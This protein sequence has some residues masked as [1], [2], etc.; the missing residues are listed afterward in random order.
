M[1]KFNDLPLKQQLGVVLVVALLITGG[2]YYSLFKPMTEANRTSREALE[3]KQAENAQLEP[4]LSKSQEMESTIAVLRGQLETLNQI[5]P[6]EKE[7]PQFMKLLQAAAASSG[8]EVRRYTAHPPASREF[9]TEVP[10]DLEL[11]GGYYAL[12]SFFQHVGKLE[13]IVNISGLQMAALDKAK[14]SIVK[15]TYQ[16]GPNE[17]VVVSCL[18]TTYF[19]A[20]HPDAPA[21]NA[22]AAPKM[23]AKK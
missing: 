2:L 5:V 10:F 22:A 21:T 20:D 16:Y 19:S 15:K 11:D 7:A 14:A 1:A 13:R 8:I 3:R 4:F 18:A 9:F 6:S 17:S 23:Q 12:L